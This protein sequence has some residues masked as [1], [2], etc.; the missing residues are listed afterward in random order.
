L[1]VPAALTL[2]V[3]GGLGADSPGD[4]VIRSYDYVSIGAAALETAARTANRIFQA[5]SLRATWRL[6]RTAAGTADGDACA[7]V[8]GPREVVVRIVTRPRAARVLPSALGYA[9]VDTGSAYGVLATIFGDTV[10]EMAAR[11]LTDRGVLLGRAVAHEVGHLLLGT[12]VHTSGLM[13][14]PWTDE[15]V[16]RNRPGDWAF[17]DHDSSAM[18]RLLLARLTAPAAGPVRGPELTSPRH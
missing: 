16:R 11:N 13:R 15:Q 2:A 4:V 7:D 17:S 18:R 10:A 8:L 14:S 5:A 12:A 3:S 9:D 1:A 6:C